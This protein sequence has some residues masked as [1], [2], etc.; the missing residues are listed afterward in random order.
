MRLLLRTPAWLYRWKCGWL[1]GHRFLL[2]IHTGRRTR[3]ERCTVLEVMAF[4]KADFEAIVMCAWGRDADWLRNIGVTPNSQVLIGSSRFTASHRV[5]GVDEA[6]AMLAGYER[7]N[8]LMAP[9]VR[10]GLSWLLGWRYDSSEPARRRAAAQ[11][12]FVAF[13]PLR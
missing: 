8:R 13:R 12:P 2:L 5:L 10:A 7:R 6:A 9:I 11:V 3:R 1:L 4:R